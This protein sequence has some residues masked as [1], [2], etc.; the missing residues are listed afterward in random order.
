[1]YDMPWVQAPIGLDAE[2][3]LTRAG[4]R[5]VLAIV[6][7]VTVGARLLDLALLLEDDHRL[8]VMFTVPDTVAARHGTA[9]FLNR[10]GALVIPWH[11]AVQHRFD[12][13]LAASYNRLEQLCGPILVV[14]HGVSCLM[15]R[16][17]RHSAGP[18]TSSHSGL[19]RE[20]LMYRGR[21]VP[22]VLALTHDSERDW[23]SQSC[24]EALPRAVVAGDICFDRLR[25]STT[26]RP[27]YRRALGVR[28]DQRL[29]TVSS[30]W[31]TDSVF[32]QHPD[33]CRRLLDAVPDDYRIALILHPNIWALY[34]HWQVRSWLASCV[35]DGLLVTP[36]EEGWR[37]LVTASDLV[38]GDHGSTTQYA[39]AIGRPVALAAFPADAVR[40]GS[41]ADAVARVSPRLDLNRALLPQ[42][43]RV[44]GLS[45]ARVTPEIAELVSSRPGRAGAIL[46]RAM[47]D[48]LRL[49]EPAGPAEV[50]AAPPPEPLW[51]DPRIRGRQ[52]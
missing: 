48:Q 12:L 35:R 5:T 30:T 41:V 14:P 15:S 13:V 8:T 4:C 45:T 38:V 52:S 23:L 28:D 21:L 49:A 11:Q 40:R 34:G 24:P 10:Q 6:P 9:E 1:M 20:T 39:A 36:P 51:L 16:R 37:A 50:P 31:F 44:A 3:R 22:S 18:S 29:V 42:V 32:G 17:Y 27:A 25:A 19:A 7:T 26:R 46:R 47:Y 43:E 33:L 2:F